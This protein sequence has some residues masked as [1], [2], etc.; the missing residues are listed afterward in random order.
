M[1]TILSISNISKGF[2]SN[3][4]GDRVLGPAYRNVIDRLSIDLERGKVTSLVGGNGAG[5]TTL[6]NLISGL[7][8]PD[9][10]EIHFL[11]GK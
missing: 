5:K 7:L 1:D 10:G 2:V 4:G 6:F 8:R 11:V 9:H 3:F